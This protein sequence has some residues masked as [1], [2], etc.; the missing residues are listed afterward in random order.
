MTQSPARPRVAWPLLILL[1]IAAGAFLYLT[2]RFLGTL[3]LAGMIVVVVWPLHARLLRLVRR[4]MPAALLSFAM[5]VLGLGG[6]A[7]LIAV[8][9]L[10]EIGRLSSDLA[11]AAQRGLIE[12]ALSRIDLPTANAWIED[13][14]GKPTDLGV[15]LFG[16][17]QGTLGDAAGTVAGQV[18]ALLQFT[19]MAFLQGLIFLLALGTFLVSGPDLVGWAR[20]F[21]P[22][23]PAHSDR[24]VE[25]FASFSRNVVAASLI[26]ALSQGLVAGLGFVLAGVERALLFGVL[27]VAGA[28]VP[29][30]GPAL[31][32]LPV[33]LLLF[34][35]GRMGTAIFVII[36]NVLL[37]GTVDNFVKPL[38]VRGRSDLPPLLIFLGVFG[39]LSTLGLIG[40]LV[41]PI[42]VAMMMAL[43]AILEEQRGL[44]EGTGGPG[45]G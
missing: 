40:L 30:V 28:L 8:V 4:K 23:D 41:G 20:R 34:S 7:T 10:P 44:S 19:G 36:W 26:G 39:G 25:I 37:T 9:V 45:G 33:S 29:I 16:A 43:F 35:E 5:L 22:L 12:Q 31:I 11:D 2:R 17:L 42:V 1:L 18:P 15:E 6:V 3:L 13:I 21:A 38:V 24:L 32:W 14:T 27:S